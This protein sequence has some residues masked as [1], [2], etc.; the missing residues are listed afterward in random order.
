M[1]FVEGKIRSRRYRDKNGVERLVTD[2][3]SQ[4][5]QMFGRKK[6]IV[7]EACDLFSKDNPYKKARD[8]SGDPPDLSRFEYDNW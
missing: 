1:I 2:I 7:S 3:V 4:K 8:G 6:E 5:M